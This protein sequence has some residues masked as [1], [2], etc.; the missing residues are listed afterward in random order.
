MIQSK[1]LGTAVVET[2]GSGDISSLLTEYTEIG[3][4]AALKDGLLKEIPIVSTLIGISRIGITIR[5]W[6]FIKKLLQFFLPLQDMPERERLEMVHRLESD[7]AYGR[8]VGEHLVEIL[9]RLET[10]HKPQMIAKI[11]KAYAARKIDARTL[12][13]LN[14]AVDRLPSYEINAVRKFHDMPAEARLN[15]NESTSQVL[16]NAGLVRSAS[17][18]GSL[19]H[20]PT[21]LCKIFITLNLDQTNT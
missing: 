3:I 19:Q 4:D 12:H 21:D 5:D 18:F 14:F 2:L 13:R 9:D 17:A 10:H 15:A 11:F 8:K 7:P 16:Q 1:D 6:L 20:L